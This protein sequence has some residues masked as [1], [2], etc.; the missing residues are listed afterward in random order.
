MVLR[1][2]DSQAQVGRIES[3]HLRTSYQKAAELL[4]KEFTS[5]T[6]CQVEVRST[7]TV[8]AHP[9]VEMV[10]DVRAWFLYQ[11]VAVLLSQPHP[12]PCSALLWRLGLR[13]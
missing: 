5:N 6:L 4:A 1:K 7:Q 8:T 10:A 11:A 12:Q 13:E 9:G 2:H 3:L